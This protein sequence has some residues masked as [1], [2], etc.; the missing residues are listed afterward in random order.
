MTKRKTE[1]KNITLKKEKTS[2]NG[3]ISV[4]KRKN[5]S[6]R[7]ISETE[8]E[9]MKFMYDKEKDWTQKYYIEERKNINQEQVY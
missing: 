2:I 8:S 4:I 1:H 5:W 3:G 6:G 7:A 9:H